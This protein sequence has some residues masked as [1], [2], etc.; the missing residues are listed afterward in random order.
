MKKISPSLA[1]AALWFAATI[2][3]APAAPADGLANIS[4]RLAVD[5]GDNVLISG[6][7][8]TGTGQLRLFGRGLGPSLA[9]AGLSNAL[10]DPVLDLYD[11]AHHLLAT[12]NNWP[13]RQAAEIEATGIP[14]SDPLEAAFVQQL[15]PGNYTALLRGAGGSEGVG[16]AELYNLGGD[17]TAHLAN[18]STRGFV[19]TGDSVMIGGVILLGDKVHD[20]VIRGLGPSL[21]AQHVA[22]A[23]QDPTL[24]LHNSNGVTVAR[25]DNWKDTQETEIKATTIPPLSEA[26]SAIRRSLPPGSYTAVLAGKNGGTGVGLVE[27]YDLTPAPTPA[28]TATPVPSATPTP[29][30]TPKPTPK[31]TSTPTP[32]TTGTP[33]PTAKPTVSP[34][35]TAKPTVTPTPTPKPTATPTP[36]PTAT[37]TPA[38][39]GIPAP[40]TNLAAVATSTTS[41]KLTWKDNSSNEDSFVIEAFD[42]AGKEFYKEPAS[43]N[44]TSYT[45]SNILTPAT[46]YQFL[47]TA[48]NSLGPS[49]NTSRVFAVTS[50]DD[51]IAPPPSNLTA[52]SLTSAGAAT[53]YSIQLDWTEDSASNVSSFVIETSD[54]G[55]S[56]NTSYGSGAPSKFAVSGSATAFR[57]YDDLLDPNTKH[58]YRVRAVTGKTATSNFSNVAA[59]TTISNAPPTAPIHV[60]A[61]AQGTDTILLTWDN[62]SPNE[63]YEVDVS[64]NGGAFQNSFYEVLEANVPGAYARQ[65]TAGTTY[66]WRVHAKNSFGLSP[67]SNIATAKTQAAPPPGAT[68]FTNNAVYPVVS[69]MIDGAE[70]FPQSPLCIPPQASPNP[71]GSDSVQLSTGMHTYK[72]LTGFWNGGTRQTMYSYS[73]NFNSG[74]AIALNNPT[75][76]QLMTRFGTQGYWL[77]DYWTGTTLHYAAFR[78][79][80]NGSYTFYNDGVVKNSGN[81]SLTS[82]PGNFTVT[83]NAGGYSGS[84]DENGGYFYMKNGP[85]D[86]Q[87][88]QYTYDG[89]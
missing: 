9:Q 23:L 50:A 28:P 26:E 68:V 46:E 47:V 83:F 38:P 35:P 6:F 59:A 82:Y 27:L 14:P 22:G 89:P 52:I 25:N 19:G 80:S 37:P 43:A 85:A 51:A 87:T 18:I 64:V 30:P 4:T 2:P 12:N 5:K 69:L 3:V 16:L 33:T 40:P 32:G 70:Q 41:V 55:I 81:Y 21:A 31:P 34:T 29:R 1:L 71:P 58:F 15:G 10:G 86:W 54:D 76:R 78:F 11:G 57:A 24:D 73:G 39:V 17:A 88:I 84:L 60:A 79:F 56:W 42:A 20:I 44:A 77:G 66:S 75:I 7:I 45:L 8:I 62:T 65:L 72:A 36:R 13:D 53:D 67:G 63:G 49:Q 74:D 61:T 48:M